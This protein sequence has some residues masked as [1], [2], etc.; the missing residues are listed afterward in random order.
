[1]WAIVTGGS[2]GIGFEFARQLAQKGFNCILISRS[3]DKLVKAI[4]ELKKDFANLDFKYLSMNF[5]SGTNI[6]FYKE[7]F[8]FVR[9]LDVCILVNNVGTAFGGMLDRTYEECRRQVVVN[10]CPQ[11]VLANYFQRKFLQRKSDLGCHVGGAIVNLSSISKIFPN[12]IIPMYAATKKYNSVLSNA[13]YYHF[14]KDLDI[15]SLMPGY[16][17]TRMTGYRKK[18]AATVTTDVCV[19]GALR[20]LGRT[21]DTHGA[22]NHV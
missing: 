8:D 7:I 13:S 22:M 3:E 15:L 2:E 12:D 16:V 10:H 1:M 9:D 19:E 21:V 20:A 4:A 18:D 5:D 6:E 14:G 17:I 11:V